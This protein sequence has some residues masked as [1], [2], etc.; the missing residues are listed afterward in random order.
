[1]GNANKYTP[2]KPM[3]IVTTQNVNT[4]INISI[5]DNGIG[6]DIQY[7]GRIFK[8]FQRLHSR[9]EYEGSGMG[10][11]ICRR[12]VERHGGGISA[13]ST[14]GVGTTFLVYLPLHQTEEINE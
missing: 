13:T 1:L 5:E 10:L 6:F 7:L 11:A 2:Q 4:G 8:P 9:A 12:I 3:I 14:P